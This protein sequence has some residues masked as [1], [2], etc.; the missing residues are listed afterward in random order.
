VDTEDPV[1]YWILEILFIDPSGGTMMGQCKW[2]TDSMDIHLNLIKFRI[3]DNQ[4]I[5]KHNGKKINLKN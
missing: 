5:V 1:S 4:T 2:L 3:N